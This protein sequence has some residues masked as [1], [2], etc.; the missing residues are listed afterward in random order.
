MQR[1][2]TI[3]IPGH[4]LQGP[5]GQGSLATVYL[6]QHSSQGRPV[7][8]KVM[9]PHLSADPGFTA[10]FMREARILARL[11]HPSLVTVYEMGEYDQQHYLSMEYLPEGSLRQRLPL[12]A[13][14]A[15]RAVSLCIDLGCALEVA[16]AAGFLH[17]DIRPESIL[18]R[19]DGTPVLSDLGLQRALDGHPVLRV[20]GVFPG[21]FSYM[22]PEALKGWDLDARSDLYGLG[23]LF[24]ELLTGRVPFDAGR[25][26]L[27]ALRSLQ[28]PIPRLP[29]AHAPCQPILERLLARN[30][31]ERFANATQVVHALRALDPEALMKIAVEVPPRRVHAPLERPVASAPVSPPPPVLLEGLSRALPMLPIAAAMGCAAVGV[32]L[33]VGSLSRPHPRTPVEAVS[34]SMAHASRTSVASPP[35]A[36]NEAVPRA[37]QRQTQ[38]IESR[39]LRHDAHRRQARAR[40]LRRGLDLVEARVPESH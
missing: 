17:R 2:E 21:D 35:R 7:A 14:D 13:G 5:L 19:E 23:I 25:S 10:R 39:N 24:H 32:H 40:G 26:L 30:R 12:W 37:A 38:E 16:H 11:D 6:A 1:T 9:A 31:N 15:L 34:A 22:S 4:T 36:R 20:E 29:A 3:H 18:L 27:S 33:I 28:N 8:L